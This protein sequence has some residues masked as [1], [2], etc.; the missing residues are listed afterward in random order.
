ML[1]GVSLAVVR[2][3][4]FA[5]VLWCV[6]V[7][8]SG[9][10]KKLNVEGGVAAKARAVYAALFV[11]AEASDSNGSSSPKSPGSPKANGSSDA[12][13]NGSSGGK[14]APAVVAAVPLLQQLASDA[15]GQ[16]AQL[17]AME[18]LLAV[19]LAPCLEVVG[20]AAVVSGAE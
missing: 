5:A 2:W 11:P 12:A 8:E 19:S 7:A 1:I 16:L 14:L 10:V 13:A 4:L 3:L 9:A 15:P 18:W 6:Q 20:V 17:V